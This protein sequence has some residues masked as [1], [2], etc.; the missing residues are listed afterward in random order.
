MGYGGA[1]MP[2][3]LLERKIKT[4]PAQGVEELS[5]YVDYLCLV[6]QAKSGEKALSEEAAQQKMREAA[7]STVWEELKNDTW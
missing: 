4:L 7:L 2:Y 1:K 6:Y 3:E 5:H